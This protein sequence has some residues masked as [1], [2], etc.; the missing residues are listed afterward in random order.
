MQA[1]L[2]YV[3][4]AKDHELLFVH[5]GIKWNEEMQACLQFPSGVARS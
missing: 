1:C 2:Q 3:I 5:G 4:G